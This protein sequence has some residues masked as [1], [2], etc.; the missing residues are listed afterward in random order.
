MAGFTWP[1]KFLGNKLLYGNVPDPFPRCGI[2]S[3]QTRLYHTLVW[4]VSLCR[5]S[6]P[7]NNLHS[8]WPAGRGRRD[9]GRWRHRILQPLRRWT[10]LSPTSCT[11][12][13]SSQGRRWFHPPTAEEQE[14]LIV[15]SSLHA[16]SHLSWELLATFGLYRLPSAAFP[17]AAPSPS[18]AFSNSLMTFYSKGSP[19]N[20]AS[21][22]WR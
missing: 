21:E 12:E 16:E 17:P 1:I 22:E 2:G 4:W 3:G 5:S 7:T 19:L 14:I 9:P 20:E 15:S 8:D 11:S 6:P 13:S 18:I 10:P